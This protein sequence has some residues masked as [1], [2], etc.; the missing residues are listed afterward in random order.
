MPEPLQVAQTR[1]MVPALAP[2]PEHAEHAVSLL[3]CKDTVT[4]SSACSN[5]KVV[6]DST[7]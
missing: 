3:S 4:P 5:V 7:S 1:G 6:S 2:V